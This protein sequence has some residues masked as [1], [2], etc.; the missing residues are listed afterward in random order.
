MR[1][2]SAVKGWVTRRCLM[3]VRVDFL[4]RIGCEERLYVNVV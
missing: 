3:V 4:Q 1:L 2:L